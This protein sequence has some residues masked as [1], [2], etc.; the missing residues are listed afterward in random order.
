MRKDAFLDSVYTLEPKSSIQK[1]S[2][3]WNYQWGNQYCPGRSGQSR[4]RKEGEN[5]YTV[6][7]KDG[8]IWIMDEE[9]FNEFIGGKENV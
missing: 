3:H 5:S 8:V 7:D 1:W 2:G 9:A 6:Q 4:W